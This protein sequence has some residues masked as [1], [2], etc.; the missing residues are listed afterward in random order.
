MYVISITLQKMYVA[1]VVCAFR[2]HLCIEVYKIIGSLIERLERILTFG[3]FDIQHLNY[4]VK[5][6][7]PVVVCVFRPHFCSETYE[8]IGSLIDRLA[9]ILTSEVVW[10]GHHF[11]HPTKNV[12]RRCCMRGPTTLL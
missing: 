4:P 7:V 11:G 8:I 9:L 12:C 10:S 3:V 6:Y 1:D 2:P 5:M